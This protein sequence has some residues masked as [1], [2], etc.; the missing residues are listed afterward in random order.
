MRLKI[1]LTLSRWLGVPVSVH[2]SFFMD[3]KK[4][5]R[6]AGSLTGPKQQADMS[7]GS[8]ASTMS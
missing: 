2:P 4:D 8:N 1:V 7:S 5:L 6:M 3:L